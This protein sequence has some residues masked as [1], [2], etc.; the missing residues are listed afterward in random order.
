[1]CSLANQNLRGNPLCAFPVCLTGFTVSSSPTWM[2]EFIHTCSVVLDHLAGGVMRVTTSCCPLSLHY[3]AN[4]FT[5]A[6]IWPFSGSDKKKEKSCCSAANVWKHRWDVTFSL[7]TTWSTET[8]SHNAISVSYCDW[9][10]GASCVVWWNQPT[11]PVHQM[12]R[13]TAD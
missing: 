10:C 7:W 8:N 12:L 13:L 3:Q 2:S 6:A 9:V 4:I 5:T 11:L 1:M